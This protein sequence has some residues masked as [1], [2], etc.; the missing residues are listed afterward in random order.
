V[1]KVNKVVGCAWG[2]GKR[3][4]GGDSQVKNDDVWDYDRE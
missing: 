1:R 3:K 4:W 2:I